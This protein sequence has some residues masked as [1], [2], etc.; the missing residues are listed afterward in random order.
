MPLNAYRGE[1]S[2]HDHITAL[3]RKIKLLE[4][5]R[6][7][8]YESSQFTI[9]K[10]RES[11][12]QMRQENKRLYR[13]LADANAGDER[14]IKVAFHDRGLEKDAFRNLSGKEA[15]TLLDQKVLSKTKRVNAL[16][17]T[18]QTYQ[19]RIDELNMEEERMKQEHRGAAASSDAWTCEKEE[20]AMDESLTYG[21]Q[22]N[23]LEAEILKYREELHNL[24]V[25]NNEAQLSK[26]ATK[27]ELEQLEVQLLKGEN[28]RNSNRARLRKVEERKSQA[29]KAEK[30]VQRT[31]MQP[32][33]LSGEAQHS[34]TRIAA[35]EEK[36][37]STFE[38]AFRSIREATGVTDMQEVLE[39]FIL[40]KENHKHL[41]KLNRENEQVLLQ[42]KEQK[43]LISQ[44]F[45]D[46]NY[47]GEAKLSSEQQMLEEC[48][49]QLLVYQ[50]RCHSAAERLGWYVKTLSTIRAGVEHL[51]GKLQDIL[52]TQDRVSEVR[53]DSDEFV[54]ELLAQCQ[55]K[56]Q[57]LQKTL[58]GK[59][60]ASVMKEIEENE[61]YTRIEGK[62]PEYDTKEKQLE[63][64]TQSCSNTESETKEEEA[65]IMSREAMKRHSQLIVD[66]NSNKKAWKNKF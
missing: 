25:R 63:S 23:S 16:K 6:T 38:L 43:K 47:S 34:T 19:Q 41:E 36:A 64:Q 44:Q 4:G 24:Q 45:E 30:K 13:Q 61:F 14:I 17:H 66:S 11:V 40:Q 10:N 53:P 28:E 2:L 5:E 9:K 48:E 32:D 58:E 50:Q 65:D 3:Q 31:I 8:S 54:L 18:T 7:A 56:L 29:E 59:D 60:L 49:R 12:L 33:E 52:P 26:K 27:A 15:I 21:G 1:Q 42:L 57:I 62:F 22:I 35:E 37:I 46:M 55:L 20:D 39:N 51:D